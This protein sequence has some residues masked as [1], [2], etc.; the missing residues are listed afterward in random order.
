[1]AKKVSVYVPSMY[2]GAPVE[3]LYLGVFSNGGEYELTDEQVATYEA[4]NANRGGT[5]EQGN[6]LPFKFPA[7]GLMIGDKTAKLASAPKAGDLPAPSVTPQ[8]EFEA[9]EGGA[10]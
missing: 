7:K 2:Q 6:P 8:A 10:G 4:L 5:D 3:V 1:M 9:G